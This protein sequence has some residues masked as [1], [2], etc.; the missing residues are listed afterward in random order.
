MNDIHGVLST[1]RRDHTLED[2]VLGAADRGAQDGKGRSS[3]RGTGVVNRFHARELLGGQSPR[4]SGKSLQK[5]R[6]VIVG[7]EV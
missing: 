2:R 3:E 5:T 1:E 7:P 4:P 6:P